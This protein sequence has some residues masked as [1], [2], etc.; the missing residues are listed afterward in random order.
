M[1]VLQRV[2]EYVAPTEC[3]VCGREGDWVCADC[4]PDFA[5]AKPST[6]YACNRLRPGGR[7]CRACRSSAPLAGV[8]VASHYDGRVKDLIGLLKYE[9]AASAAD[10]LAR[11]MA[12][13][14]ADHAFDVVTSVPAPPARLRQRG[15]NQ[16]E[17]I[18]RAVARTCGWPYQRLLARH[19]SSHQ[20]GTGRRA[21]LSQVAGAFEITGHAAA[22]GQ[23]ILI[24]DDVLTTGAT[25]AECAR[26]LRDAG[27]K[28]I[29]GAVAAKH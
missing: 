27:A 14:L 6:C 15:Y 19:G 18:A 25:M 28:Q 5:I 26:V 20:V 11:M 16:A 9:R 10:I 17:L 12:P 23:R 8:V 2:I 22:T 3:L 1:R 29:W 24:V 21:R 7:T 13:L 4:L